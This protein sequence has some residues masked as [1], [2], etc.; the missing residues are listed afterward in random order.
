[1]M[2]SS[3]KQMKT[4]SRHTHK[5]SVVPESPAAAVAALRC[6]QSPVPAHFTAARYNVRGYVD[7][8]HEAPVRTKAAAAAAA[9]TYGA[10]Q[11]QVWLVHSMLKRPAAAV[12]AC[13]QAEGIHLHLD[14]E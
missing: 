6:R 14:G 7:V 5:L 9:S 10:Q 13:S 11:I 12:A 3:I 2:N 1:M 8:A 4:F